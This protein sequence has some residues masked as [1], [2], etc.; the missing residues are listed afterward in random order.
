MN[1]SRN[2]KAFTLVELLVTLVITGILLSA[3]ATLAFAM[4]SAATTGSDTAS[5]QARLRLGMVRIVEVIRNCRMILTASD[6]ELAIWLAD[7]NGDAGINVNELAFLDCTATHDTL[8]LVRFYSVSDPSVT[9]SSGVLSVSQASL[10]SGNAVASVSLLPA[11]GNVQLACDPAAPSTRRVTI[12][13]ELTQDHV[14]RT[15]EVDVTL[16]AWAGH[17]LN[18]TGDGLV[19]GDDD[20]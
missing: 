13:F 7:Y 4:N 8:R 10:V 6:T 3:V 5:S 18:A 20:E 12:S 14:A 9:L 2:I 19:T 11:C 17:L 1:R 15:H 16:L